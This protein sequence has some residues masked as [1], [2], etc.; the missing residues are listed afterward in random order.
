MRL[1]DV[2]SRNKVQIEIE[3]TTK[4]KQVTIR[5]W[6]KGVCL[7]DEV[8][9][10]D[11]KSF[12]RFLVKEGQ[13][14]ISKIDARHGAFGMIPNELE[15]AVIT[16]DFLSYNIDSSKIIPEYFHWF[17]SQKK[18][19]DLCSKASS[20]TTNRIRLRE[21][22]FLDIEIEI[23]SLPEQEIGLKLIEAVNNLNTQ[24]SNNLTKNESYVTKLQQAILSEAVQGKLVPQDPNDEPASVFLEKIKAVKEDLIKE[25]KIRKEKPLPEIKEEEIPYELPKGWVWARAND[26]TNYIQRGKSPKYS[27]IEKIPVVSQKCVRWNGFFIER[28]RFI[29]PD[30]LDKYDEARFLKEGDLLW[31]STG[32]GTIG[33]ICQYTENHD[34][35]QVVADSHVTIVRGFSEYVLPKYLLAWFS[36]KYVQNNLQ[37][38]GST[39]QT[40]LGT[41]TVKQHI[42]PLP[43]INEQSRIV[44]KM[45]QLMQLCDQLE[46]QVKANQKNSEALMNSVLREAFEVEA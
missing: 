37:V 1:G 44:E 39:K 29:D 45:D 25:K 15:G 24:F 31:N 40:E 7:R 10:G 41:G 20:G 9:G 4:Y 12:K 42:V 16:A 3:D 28:A 11:I 2:L 43:P 38:T 26:I 17:F 27:Q 36:S 19:T 35:P 5:M 6:N 33:R 14:I 22:K 13:F 21:N 23:P 34:Y 46:S 8:Y 18:F 30:M 32:E